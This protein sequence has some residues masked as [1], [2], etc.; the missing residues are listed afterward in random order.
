MNSSNNEQDNVKSIGNV[1]LGAVFVTSTAVVTLARSSNDNVAHA[2]SVMAAVPPVASFQV[3]SSSRGKQQRNQHVS[4]DEDKKKL[5]MEEKRMAASGSSDLLSTTSAKYLPPGL[6]IKITGPLL[7][8]VGDRNPPL[9]T[10][11]IVQTLGL[12]LTKGGMALRVC[13]PHFQTT[14]SSKCRSINCNFISRVLMFI[15]FY[16]HAPV[17]KIIERPI[18]KSESR[19][20]QRRRITHAVY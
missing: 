13:V 16:S 5:T 15:H 10:I 2:D 4:K 1:L 6:M 17:Y 12:I 7:R 3:S 14:V 18:K 8:A 9:V 20:N 11:A 19:S